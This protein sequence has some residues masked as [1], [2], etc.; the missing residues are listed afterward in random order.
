MKTSSCSLLL[1]LLISQKSF[2]QQEDNPKSPWAN[3]S[4]VAVVTVTGNS[5]S[6]SYSAKQK[7]AYQFS[8]NVLTLAG[9]FL[10]TRSVDKTTLVRGD[11]ARSWDASLRYDRLLSES[12]SLYAAVGAE[13][14]PFA[15]YIQKDNAE[16]GGKYILIKDRWFAELG[17]R[18]TRV[19]DTALV[20]S[21]VNYGR[22]YT[23][24][25]Q[26]I[27]E[28]VSFKFWLEYL[29]NFTDSAAYI[30]IGE[31]SLSVM[32][33]SVFSLKTS[34]NVKYTAGAVSPLQKTDTQLTTSLV[35]KF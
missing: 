14:N 19:Y 16:L 21:T 35:A 23:E 20:K 1:L 30:V 17:Y 10:N 29:P 5:E 26:P 9:K 22:L 2:A 27:N 34:Y 4:E 6:E 18:N 15:G 11:T 28:S 24:Y 32:L 31:P 8:S 12:W 13:S 7:T 33:S 25:A 3:E